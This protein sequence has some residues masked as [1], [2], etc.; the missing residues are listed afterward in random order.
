[1]NKFLAA[2]VCALLVFQVGCISKPPDLRSV[3][4]IKENKTDLFVGKNGLT[5]NVNEAIIEVN[6]DKIEEIY[7]TL[8]KEKHTIVELWVGK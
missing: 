6:K 5:N 7:N 4:V 8:D 2:I 1:M 3:Y